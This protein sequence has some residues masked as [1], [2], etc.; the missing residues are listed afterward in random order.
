MSLIRFWHLFLGAIGLNLQYYG[1]PQPVDKCSGSSV[2]A[3]NVDSEKTRLRLP[4][5]AEFL[6]DRDNLGARCP[7]PALPSTEPIE[8]RTADP[9]RV[10]NNT[11]MMAFCLLPI[12]L[13]IKKIIHTAFYL[14]FFQVHARLIHASHMALAYML[15]TPLACFVARY[16][17]ETFI[18]V[19]C[20][21]EYWWYMWHVVLLIAAC[22]LNFG[23]VLSIARNKGT[24]I[25]YGDNLFVHVVLGAMSIFVFYLEMFTG[26]FRVADPIKRMKQIFSHWLI[27]VL[28]NG[29]AGKHEE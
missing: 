2:L 20:F 10:N 25:K 15:L 23:A 7:C 26:F 24:S 14:L 8:N 4:T 21:Q 28:N 3:D 22:M 1:S 6:S 12:F 19:F 18:T 13:L 5:V 11:D 17:K 9:S 29:C 16:Y 27:G